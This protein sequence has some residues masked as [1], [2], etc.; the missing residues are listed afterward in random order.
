MIE[1]RAKANYDLVSD[2]EITNVA[3]MSYNGSENEQ[4]TS[5]NTY[6]I[7]GGVAEGY[8]FTH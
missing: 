3:N 4:S 5:N 7:A 1:Y 8:V 6:Q 2:G